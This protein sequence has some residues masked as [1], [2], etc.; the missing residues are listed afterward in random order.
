MLSPARLVITAREHGV[1]TLALTDH[2]TTAGLDDA[3]AEG[4]RIHVNVIPG[5]EINTDVD[6]YEIHLLGYYID[7]TRPD[8]QA[9]LARMRGGRIDRARTMVEKLGAL[10]VPVEWARVEAIAAG[11]SVGRPHV[12]RALVEARRVATVQEAFE[13][14]LGRHAE[15]YVPRLKVLPEEAVEA[16]RAGGGVPVLAHPGWASS[17]PVIDRVPQL[18]AHGLAGIEVYYP[19]HTPEMIARYLEV[20]RRHGLVAT[21][22]TDF[23]GGGLATRVAPGSVRVPPEVVPALR[24]RWQEAHP[25]PAPQ[26]QKAA[27]GR[28]P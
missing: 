9:F 27:G 11:A 28:G 14:F 15:A 25:W 7:H 13:R 10:G 12:A 4:R 3:L 17:G 19:D 1:G 8:F 20:A 23:H 5:V 21:G 16:V 18:V 26:A 22:G 24:A 2:D 6:D